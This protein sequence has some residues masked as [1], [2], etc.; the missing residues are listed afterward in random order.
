MLNSPGVLRNQISTSL[1]R[2]WRILGVTVLSLGSHTSRGL[3]VNRCQICVDKFYRG[4]YIV[5]VVNQISFVKSPTCKWFSYALL[6]NGRASAAS[7]SAIV[8]SHFTTALR[9]AT[10]NCTLHTHS[11]DQRRERTSDMCMVSNYWRRLVLKSKWQTKGALAKFRSSRSSSSGYE[12]GTLQLE[13][14]PYAWGDQLTKPPELIVLSHHPTR[15][16]GPKEREQHR[17]AG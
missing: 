17:I 13:W 6:S 12:V 15:W 5:T 11:R 9:F 2:S 4:V 3:V 8:K 10:P 7:F 16:A 1:E 14:R